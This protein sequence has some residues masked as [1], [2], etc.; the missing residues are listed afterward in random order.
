MSRTRRPVAIALRSATAADLPA[1]RALLE[2]SLLPVD[3]LA[4]D[5][6]SEFLLAED[7]ALLGV[8]GLEGTGSARLLR[9][10][11]VAERAQGQRLGHRLLQA[12]ELRARAQGAEAV[13]L[14][15]TTAEPFFAH[16]GYLRVPRESAPAGLKLLAEFSNVCP[17]NAACM[18][19]QLA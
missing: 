2:A 9:S 7:S 18:R 16:A 11:A 10:L 17:S 8:V 1:V 5:L 4:A 13:F 6:L 14:L 19:K 15:T 3:D 12:I